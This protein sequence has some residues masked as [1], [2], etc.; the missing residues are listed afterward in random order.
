MLS[1]W[2]RALSNSPRL[3]PTYAGSSNGFAMEGNHTSTFGSYKGLG[4]AS[5][6]L[7][8]RRDAAFT[9]GTGLSPLLGPTH[10]GSGSSLTGMGSMAG[11]SYDYLYNAGPSYNRLPSPS[12]SLTSPTS[13]PLVLAHSNPTAAHSFSNLE[14]HQSM[15]PQILPPPLHPHSPVADSANLPTPISLKDTTSV[16]PLPVTT[17]SPLSETTERRMSTTS[18]LPMNEDP[19]I[20]AYA[21]LEFPTFDMYIQKLSV[22]IG[23]RPAVVVPSPVSPV[24]PSEPVQVEARAEVKLE[25]FVVGLAEDEPGE[26]GS[27][28]ERG[29]EEV[30]LA[31]EIIPNA[32]VKTELDLPT[33]SFTPS[34]PPASPGADAR[35]TSQ[36]NASTFTPLP[37]QV[38]SIA[39]S[40]VESSSAV[41]STPALPPITHLEPNSVTSAVPA[42]PAAPTVQIIPAIVTDIDLG[43]IR[44]V[45]RQHARLYFDY[46]LGGWAIEVLGRNGVVVEGTW[47]AKGEKESLGR[48]FV[49]ASI[50]LSLSLED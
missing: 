6:M 25:D 35:S 10:L 30:R 42:P 19:R 12:R 46:E 2:A 45:S 23:R 38:E 18:D 8:A 40:T 47:K 48:R 36:L 9:V 28:M 17:T 39:T 34:S 32:I 24:L 5:P 3:F 44:A 16:A 26:E 11:G 4:D 33:L 43:P 49:S 15:S 14:R 41:V 37:L 22:I 29:A 50:V 21:K 1:G 27:L 31:E 7:E 13:H 20:R